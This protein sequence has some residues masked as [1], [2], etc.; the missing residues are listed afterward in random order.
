MKH[1]YRLRV[2]HIGFWW[3]GQK[4]RAHLKDLDV[5]GGIIIRTR[6]G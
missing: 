3:E 1:A 6:I 4:E 5:R 2:K